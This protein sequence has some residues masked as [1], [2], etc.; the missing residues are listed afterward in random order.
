MIH[1]RKI[2]KE[3]L[4]K[5]STCKEYLQVQQEGKRKVSR[6]VKLLLKKGLTESLAGRFELIRI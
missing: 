1:I 5:E 3:E 6:V 4:E 2:Q